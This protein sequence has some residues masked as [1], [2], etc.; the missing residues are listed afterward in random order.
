MSDEI[1]KRIEELEREIL[2]LKGI[3]AILILSK[4][5]TQ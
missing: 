1:K 4:S 3:T 2:L 5:N